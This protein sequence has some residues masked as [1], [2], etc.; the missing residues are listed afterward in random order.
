MVYSIDERVGVAN[1]EC[2]GAGEYKALQYTTD[3]KK[4]PR[5]RWKLCKT[6]RHPFLFMEILREKSWK[7]CSP[8]IFLNT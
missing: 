7:Q 1:M 6:V 3:S 2:V 4:K 8:G 5:S